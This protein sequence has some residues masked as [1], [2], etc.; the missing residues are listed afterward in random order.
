M[1]TM[2]E[3]KIIINGKEIH[4]YE[5][6]TILE[7]VREHKLDDIPTLCHDKRIEPFGSCFLCVVEVK[8]MNRLLP[9]CATPVREGMEIITNN[10]KIH[11]SRKTAL[12]L[13]LSNHYADC[14]GPCIN[15]CPANVDA[16]GYIALISRGKYDEALK[17]VKER[18][19]LPL[20][21]GRVCVRDCELV[22]RRKYVDE[23]VSINALKRYVADLD[24]T[25]WTPT[26]KNGRKEKVAVIGAGP[27]GLTCA[28]YLRLEGF[29]VKIFEKLS[30]AGGMLRY[31][32]PEYR[33][34]KE[35]L[36]Q[37]IQWILNTGIEMETGVAMGKDFCAADLLK[38]GYD[39]VYLSVGSHKAS[40]M[41]LEGEDETEGVFRGIDFLREMTDDIGRKLKGI[42]VVV[43]GGNT[44]IDAART[45]RRMGADKVIMVYRRTI[46][47][48]PA[49]HEEIQAA[50]NEGIDIKIL[51]NPK[52]IISKNGKLQGIEC[53]QM[54]LQDA[55]PGRRPRPVPVEG[56]EFEISCDYL[57]G[58]IGQ[59]LDT[60]FMKMDADCK[61]N[62][63]GNIDVDAKT[64]ET[65][66]K[67]VFAGG[68]AVTG[69]LTAISSI[70]QGRTAA[71]SIKSY[72]INGIPIPE[73]KKFYSFKHELDELSEREF[74]HFPR[75]ERQ[76]MAEK[77]VEI[78]IHN[79]EEVELGFSEE[80]S[81]DETTR[82][83][84]CGCSE[85]YD[86]QL[87]IYSDEYQI[88]TTQLKGEARKYD[89]DN[90][91][92]LI[93]FDP[94]KCINCGKCVRTCSE[95]LKVSALGFVY[96]GFK[97][98]VKPAMEKEL[99]ET[100]CIS[101]GNCID[102]CPTG[103]I[104]EN[105][106]QKILGTI[107][108]QN[109]ETLCNFCSIGCHVNYK[110]LYGD[111][112]YISNSTEAITENINNGYLCI[113]GRFGYR[114][115]QDKGRLQDA[116]LRSNGKEEKVSVSKALDYSVEKIQAIIQKYGPE[117]VAVMGS[118]KMTNEEAYLLQKMARAGLKTNN[119]GSFSHLFDSQDMNVLDDVMGAT[120][121][122]V[123]MDD[124]KKADLIV[125]IN[126]GISEENL[127]MELQI[128]KAQKQ[129]AQ[130]LLLN[131]SEIKITKFAD[132]WIDTNKGTNTVLLNGLIN[133]IIDHGHFDKDYVQE[134]IR[135]FNK[136]KGMLSVFDPD[137][138]CSVTGLDKDKYELFVKLLSNAKA[139]VVFVYNIDNLREKSLNDLKAIANFLMLTKRIDKE[140]NG[141]LILRNYCNAQG[142]LEMG[143]DP[144]YLPG[145][146]KHNEAAEIKK[147]S[148]SWN[149]NLS[150]VF[151]PCDLQKS[152]SDHAIKAL[153][154]FGE[155]PLHNEQNR[156]LLRNVDFV[157][158][159]DAY[160]TATS[161]QADVLIPTRNFVENSGTMYS[162]DRK[163]HA[164]NEVLPSACM[165][166]W[167][168]IAELSS[169]FGYTMQYEKAEDILDEI[170]NSIEMY[171]DVKPNEYAKPVSSKKEK[172]FQLFENDIKV[173]YKDKN[174]YLFSENFYIANVRNQIYSRI[175]HDQYR[176]V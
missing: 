94:N 60:S 89:V 1:H 172:A 6:K 43:G 96:R 175:K 143:L 148:Q 68:D 121:S 132:L 88:D 130:L 17:L 67:G 32:I 27:S 164:V 39:A 34:P 52:S 37:E 170:R 35:V 84:E 18:N 47:E 133:E 157:L 154:L 93:A 44:A 176:R 131:S 24:A 13:L 117:S 174:I 10:D 61:L 75:K 168:L 156:V 135:D 118:P 62:D 161:N 15:N 81:L 153:I 65:S 99:L 4:T 48:M 46:K 167:K 124:L 82:C 3:I 36:D 57:I 26:I 25:A 106:N 85:Y 166:N 40:N 111:T 116:L 101:C 58:A 108:K 19:P 104:S 137:N 23:P 142:I 33:L 158:S 141:L 115:L 63:W 169:G 152:F 123:T 149:T 59:A 110:V 54:K 79:F 87:R 155:D 51:T 76:H 129:G 95:I 21:I 8:G 160:A 119:V 128:K 22:C 97:A 145:F 66:I 105:F 77:P 16:Q 41:G 147:L 91:H 112:C 120:S 69:P 162:F 138:V 72:L 109:K 38:N 113:K 100:N 127:I 20:S 102:V 159:M 28:Y 92:P 122:T 107:P 151:S 173:N 114:Y 42:V 126:S 30:K 5:G 136:L 29:H 150:E 140:N 98:V 11:S 71:Q 90:R 125:A 70:A 134:N 78:R 103:A 144:R 165:E 86:C 146:V 56:S 31:G 14:I 53:L 9:S 55:G 7:V 64:L 139:N 12:E 163:L 74:E 83:I 45:A 73:K 171:R 80:Q 49:H 50:Q 2:K